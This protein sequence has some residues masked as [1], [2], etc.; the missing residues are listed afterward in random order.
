MDIKISSQHR[1]ELLR[2]LLLKTAAVR[3]GVKPA[4][5][6]RV[7][8]CYRT[9]NAEG[10]QFCL[11]RKDILELMRL[12][13]CELRVDNDSSLILFYHRKK[14]AE[15]L[16]QPAVQKV[17]QISG[18]PA[19]DGIDEALRFLCDRFLTEKIPH[20]VGVFIGYPVK[21]VV[22]F[23]KNLPRTPVHR[24]DWAVFGNAQESIKRMSLY[25][26]VENIAKEAFEV[27]DD[28][29]TFFDRISIININDRSIANG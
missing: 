11:Y 7:Q 21:D 18:Y 19:K 2:F 15:V 25:R 28:L 5:L 12:E 23:M 4:E 24:G 3:S 13:Y 17:L 14:L 9:R 20:E 8:H 26:Q 27:C 1:K 22:G 10:F 29:Q 6:L 16:A